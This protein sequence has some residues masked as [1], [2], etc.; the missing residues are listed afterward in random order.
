MRFKTTFP[1]NIGNYTTLWLIFNL[2]S[3]FFFD[4]GAFV[5]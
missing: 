3:K 1:K 5:M 2:V 4:I